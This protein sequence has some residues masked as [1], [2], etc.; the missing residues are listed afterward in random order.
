MPSP[1]LLL[2]RVFS[3][4]FF[5]WSFLVEEWIQCDAENLGFFVSE[6]CLFLCQRGHAAKGF[7]GD[8]VV[9]LLVRAK[10]YLEGTN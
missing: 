1:Q 7:P 4:L 5:V 9:Q 8:I 10:D 3:T 6:C 2:A